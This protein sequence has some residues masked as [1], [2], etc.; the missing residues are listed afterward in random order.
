MNK[1]CQDSSR[2]ANIRSALSL[3][4]GNTK[5]K[6]FMKSA[7]VNNLKGNLKSIDLKFNISLLEKNN[8]FVFL[9]GASTEQGLSQS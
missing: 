2:A 6:S 9:C 3:R 4:R 1:L 7:W 8:C 5:E